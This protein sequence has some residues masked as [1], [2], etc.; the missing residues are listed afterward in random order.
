MLIKDVN[1]SLS[2]HFGFGKWMQWPLFFIQMKPEVKQ[3]NATTYI[4]S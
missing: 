1:I 3:F 2:F 4:I